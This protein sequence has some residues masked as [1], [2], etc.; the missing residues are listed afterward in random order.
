MSFGAA[1]AAGFARPLKGRSTT[2]VVDGREANAAFARA[3]LPLLVRAFGRCTVLDLDALY[4]SGP[5]DV[6]GGLSRG[7]SESVELLVPGPDEELEEALAQLLGGCRGGAVV[8]DSL[9]SL[10]HL[11]STGGRGSRGRSLAYTSA[12]L[13]YAA[14]GAGTAA[15]FT[16][17]RRD[18]GARPGRGRSI[19]DA[20]DAAAAATLGGGRL[21]LKAQRGEL[22][23]GGRLAL[24]TA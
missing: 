2:F 16:M 20:T 22:W 8:V 17:Y 18:G 12:L 1:E 6:L 24:P 21:E 11:F 3:T 7:E 10:Y 13:S 15:V 19:S 4:A 14:R 5:G 9:N 23:P